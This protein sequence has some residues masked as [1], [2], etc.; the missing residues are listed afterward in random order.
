MRLKYHVSPA[1][2]A[3]RIIPSEVEESSGV[4]IRNS[5]RKHASYPYGIHMHNGGPWTQQLF[6]PN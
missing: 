1:R 4:Q 3:A 2:G 5:G 6:P